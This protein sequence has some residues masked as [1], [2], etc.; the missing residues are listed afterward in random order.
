MSSPNA[1]TLH[2]QTESLYLSHH[3]WLLGWLYRRLGC[4]DTSA[5]LAHDTFVRLLRKSGSLNIKEPRAYLS[6]VAHG[7]VVNHWRRKDIE[8]AYLRALAARPERL[9]PSPE[10]RELVIEALETAVAIL[11]GLPRRAREVFVLSQMDGL[12]YPQIAQRLGITVD[13]VQ[14]DMIK[15]MSRC[16]IAVYD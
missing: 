11:D 15:V 6:T 10:E 1:D 5:D 3:D 8:K 14:K 13:I 9:A 12:T 7:L 16:Y 2:C 4:S